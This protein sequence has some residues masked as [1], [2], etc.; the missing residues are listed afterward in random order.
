MLLELLESQPLTVRQVCSVAHA[1]WKNSN[2]VTVSL[3]FTP[4]IYTVKSHY[5]RVLSHQHIHSYYLCF[6][7]LKLA[8]QGSRGGFISNQ[9]LI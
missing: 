4:A 1:G 2:S 9:L 8:V 7:T 3:V 5:Q 6:V